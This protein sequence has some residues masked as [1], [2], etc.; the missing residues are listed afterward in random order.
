MILDLTFQRFIGII[1]SGNNEK[2]LEKEAFKFKNFVEKSLEGKVLGPVN[3][4]IY[5]LKKSISD[6]DD[7]GLF[8]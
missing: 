8:S 2:N 5:R 4:P 6:K 7:Y 1:I 3:A